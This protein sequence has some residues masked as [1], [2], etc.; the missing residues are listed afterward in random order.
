MTPNAPLV[1]VIVP[2]YNGA[3]YLK[4]TLD[5]IL[6]NDYPRYEI[7][8]VDD[9]STDASP[10]ICREYARLHPCI[11]S[12]IFHENKGLTAALNHAVHEAQG[13]YIARINQDDLMQATRLTKQVSFLES[14]PDHS[15]V[16]SAIR[17]F[18]NGNNTV[19]TVSFPLDDAEIK[20]NWLVFSPF[21]DPAVMYRKTAFLRTEGYQR[22][23]WPVD[24]VHMWYQLGL[25]GKLANL[26]DV[27]T[28]VRWHNEA[29]SIKSHRTQV[30]KLYRLHLWANQH[31]RKGN[32]FEWLFWISQYAA[33]VL[34]HPRFNWFVFR[35]L[36]KVKF[37]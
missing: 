7:L 19:D 2:V 17:L 21:A 31:I 15:T 6:K 23:F 9:G 13:E 10:D 36:R 22:Q 16:G 14:H 28:D 24:D 5:S 1:S 3:K 11:R 18:D 29:G 34:F 35:L 20:K 26:P 27:L 30:Q 12:Y 8:L 32:A 4:E 25:Q 37:S 33:G